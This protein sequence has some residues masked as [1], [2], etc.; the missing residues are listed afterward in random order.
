MF[1]EKEK[2]LRNIIHQTHTRLSGAIYHL[3]N[4]RHT[5]ADIVQQVYIRIWENL[6]HIENDEKIFPLLRKYSRNI[7]L[8]ELKRNRIVE[9]V[10]NTLPVEEWDLSSENRLLAKEQYQQIQSAIRRLPPQQQQIFR[11][12]KEQAMSYKQIEAHLGI[13]G[14]T[15]EKQMNR[16]LKFL[17]SELKVMKDDSYA[18]T[19]LLVYL[20]S[21]Q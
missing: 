19:L 8:N 14:G 9:K 13:S 18:L 4:D 21:S 15:I 17:R 16:A 12:H 3:C 10:H 7:F 2:R 20:S 5:T 6:D 11:M 1:T